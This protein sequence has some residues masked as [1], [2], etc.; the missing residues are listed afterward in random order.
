MNIALIGYGNIAKKHIEVFRGLGA[1][2]VASSNRSERNNS[3]AKQEAGIPHTFTDFHEMIQ[4][5]KPDAIVV[6]VSAENVFKVTSELISTYN[7]PL[8]IEK[9][10]GNSVEEL[11]QLIRLKDK[12]NACV[13]VAVNRRHYS[14]IN[15][16]IKDIG[17]EENITSIN[18]EW[19]EN[20][21]RVIK[22]KGY[23]DK[24]TAELI[25]S[26]SIHGID[27]LLY[28]GGNLEVPNIITK[29][30]DQMFRCHMHITGISETGKLLSFSSSWDNPVPW[31]I[32]LSAKDTR[33]VFAPL[34]QCVATKSDGTTYT[35]EP[36][37]ED[38]KY[39]AGFY[40]QAQHFLDIAKSKTIK[41]PH[42]LNSCSN[43]MTIAEELFKKLFSK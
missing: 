3:L 28:F 30:Y 31:R 19:S 32:V 2:I 11:N 25:Y 22:Q 36:N 15:N 13:Q 35:I 7:I 26:N 23:S 39:K 12:Y 27:T 4:Q 10:P 20:P 18:I 17:G 1:T 41:H 14:I 37:E 16:A 34:E 42:D 6:C 24:Q 8:L 9:P 43:S 38:K 21:T 40:L 29:N 33:Y 5:T